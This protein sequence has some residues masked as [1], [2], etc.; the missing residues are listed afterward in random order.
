MRRVFVTAVSLFACAA[1]SAAL[2]DTTDPMGAIRQYIDAFNKGDVKTMAATCAPQSSILDGFPPHSWQGPNAC[3]VWYKEAMAVGER[4]GASDYLVTL[5]EPSV[6][7]AKGDSA[8]A[9][10]PATMAFKLRGKQVTQSGATWTVALQKLPE[11]WRIAAW[12]W[13]KG[14]PP[15]PPQ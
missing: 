1:A 7:N 2:A 13:A 15:P 11:G 4:E 8:Y 12:A 5:G 14:K 3:E 10:I 9:V 6:L